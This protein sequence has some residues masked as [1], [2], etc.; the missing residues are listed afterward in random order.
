MHPHPA[1]IYP[2]SR[3]KKITFRFRQRLPAAAQG[4]NIG[5]NIGRSL[6]VMAVGG[7]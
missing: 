7:F 3:L 4:I 1:K 6:V 2:K 5:F